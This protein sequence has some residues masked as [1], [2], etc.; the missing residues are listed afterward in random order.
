MITN[1]TPRPGPDIRDVI[2]IPGRDANFTDVL[3]DIKRDSNPSYS[4]GIVFQ[5]P[6][7]WRRERNALKAA[8]LQ[9][10]ALQWQF[11]Q[12]RQSIQT[13]IDN[14]L[15]SARAN[16]ERAGATR[17]ATAF[18]QAAL[19]AEMKKMEA[20]RS[21]P[22]QVLQ[23]QRDLTNRRFEEIRALAD[24]N[25]ALA[26]LSFAEGTILDRNKIAIDIR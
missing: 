4:Y 2:V 17:Q 18:A 8:K 26:E 12:L 25:K 13:G 10:D 1:V 20:G 21:T 14:A 6:L 15:T 16:F 9:R 11:V 23:L 19:D 5:T 7:G 3:D 24:Y 22:F